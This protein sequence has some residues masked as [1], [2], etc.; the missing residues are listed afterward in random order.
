MDFRRDPLGYLRE[1]AGRYGNVV[2]LWAGPRPAVLFCHP[3]QVQ[4]VLQTR[5]LVYQ[6]HTTP[7][8]RMRLVLGEGLVTTTG[9]AWARARQLL[10]PVFQPA[11]LAGLTEPIAGLAAEEADGWTANAAAGESVEMHHAML[12]LSFRIASAALF[13]TDQSETA[14]VGSQALQEIERQADDRLYD[15]IQWPLWPPTPANR[16]FKQALRTLEGSVRS[17]IRDHPP[18]ANRRDLLHLLKQASGVDGGRLSEREL[19][20]H[21]LTMLLAAHESTGNTLSWVWHLLSHHP[22][23]QSRLHEEADRVLDGR[24]ATW[25]DLSSLEYTRMVTQE[26]IRLW[27]ASWL[28]LRTAVEEDVLGDIRVP[29]GALVLLSPFVTHRL[30]DFW[31]DPER[32][33]PLRFSAAAS[34]GRHR[35]AF[36]PF[37]GGPRRCIGEGFALAAIALVIATVAQRWELAPSP[38]PSVEPAPRVFLGLRH[39][40]RLRLKRRIIHAAA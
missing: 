16:R 28:L 1:A 6:K 31:P 34:A 38:A 8:S 12:R 10:Q 21:V 9:K 5:H 13:G 39:G 19:R 14:D 15:L 24:L 36:F 7:L 27:P 22:W 33:D 40:L 29:R 25:A 32:F 37:G 3:D 35:F 4:A 17:I 18:Q 26:A 2:G 11:A 23:A 30:P 20:D